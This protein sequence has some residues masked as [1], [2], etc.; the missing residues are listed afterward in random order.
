MR[1]GTRR[2][3]LVVV[4]AGFTG[5]WVAYEAALDGLEVLVVDRDRVGGGA[6]GRCG[7]FVN[8]SITHGLG[9]GHAHWPAEMAAIV[10]LQN[11]LWDD[12]LKLLADHGQASLIEPIGKLSVATR[13]HHADELAAAAALHH[14]YD[15]PARVLD[16]DELAD[17]VRSPTYL[18]GLELPASNGLC[19]PARLAWFLADL[20]EDAGATIAEGTAV[21]SIGRRGGAVVLGVDGATIEADR[22]LLA[23]NAAPPLLRRLRPRM[24]PVYD[25]VITTAPLT[26]EQWDSIGWHGRQGI[27]DAGNQFHYYRPTPDGGI[28]FGGWDATYFYGSRTD[29]ALEQRRATHELLVRHLV[30]TFPVLRGHPVSHTWGGA[31]DST[32]R[33]TPTFGTSRDRRIAWAIGHTGLGVG[34]SRFAA[35]SALDLLAGRSTDR[36]ALTMVRRGPVP[37]PPEPLRWLV[38]T[39]TKRSLVAEDRTG[40]RNLWLRLLDRF[41]IGFDT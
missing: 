18:G 40:R 39:A 26:A 9:N 31:I 21:G 8:A 1:G 32:T 23:T 33:F 20:A 14:R 30:E 12:T 29:P 3:D 24:I 35:L 16:A 41:G 28:L 25:H 27:T 11:A 36:T 4:G 22:V 37:F 38:V 17:R 7:G 15:L 19:D 6:S 2:V 13:P 5:L 10:A 34:S